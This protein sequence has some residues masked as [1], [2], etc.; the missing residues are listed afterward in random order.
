MEDDPRR[1]LAE[2]EA[3]LGDAV[4]EEDFATIGRLARERD[5]LQAELARD[6]PDEGRLDDLEEQLRRLRDE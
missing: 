6:D 3:A 2:I 4:A 1:R 5:A